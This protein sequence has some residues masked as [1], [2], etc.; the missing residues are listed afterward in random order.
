MYTYGIG[1]TS[2]Y[3]SIGTTCVY[4][5]L[6]STCVY[7]NIGTICVYI[8]GTTCVYIHTHLNTSFERFFS[9]LPSLCYFP[10]HT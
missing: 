5:S 2:V 4:N 10:N 8:N 9:E 7:N 3:N 6:G 1:T